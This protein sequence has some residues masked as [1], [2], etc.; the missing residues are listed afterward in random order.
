MNKGQLTPGPAHLNLIKLPQDS[1][2]P[3]TPFV[4]P[5][6]TVLYLYAR[7][8]DS[9]TANTVGQDYLTFRYGS[10]DLAFAVCDGV[11]QSFIGDLAARIV[12][13]GLLNWLWL[14]DQRPPDAETFSEAVKQALNAMT[15]M[16][17]Q[18]VAEYDLPPSLPPILRQA[19]ENQ[20]QYGSESMF[21]A[22][23]LALGG[24]DPWIALCWLGDSPVAAIDIDGKLVDLGPHG[25]TSERWNATTGV[26][27][28]VHTWVG[29]A[30][31]VAR[32]AGYTDGLAASHV[33][34]DADLA[35]MM[36]M[37]L[38]NPPA[39]DA[40]LFDVRLAYSPETVGEPQ[41]EPKQR[42]LALPAAIDLPP[43]EMP[44]E[45]PAFRADDT[46][47]IVVE[48]PRT[49]VAGVEPIPATS[50]VPEAG[51]A[52]EEWRPLTAKQSEGAKSAARPA[53]AGKKTAGGPIGTSEDLS[54]Q[55]QIQMWQRAALHG[56]TSAAL[57]ML[58]LERLIKEQGQ[59][60][61]S[62]S[63]QD[64]S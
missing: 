18:Q 13:D 10:S 7:S 33:P 57:A 21:V 42:I 37:W 62:S 48:E 40:T 22:G 54:P 56:L 64:E 45:E 59:T 8:G 43:L 12:G 24:S 41:E 63:G 2:T 15:A 38:T 46:R 55:Q 32:V 30:Q 23:R 44:E 61:P 4:T 11:G 58:M 39:D 29:S 14:L 25:H 31:K 19:L 50:T 20:R 35:R 16:S 53:Q 51:G 1:E 60:P 9:V 5:V 27:G 17:A 36:E 47:P 52:V 6:G 3:L 28:E 34:T 26:K 49:P